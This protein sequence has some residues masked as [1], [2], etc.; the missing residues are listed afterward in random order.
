[1]VA[2][3]E[4]T[5]T[6]LF[7]DIE[8]ST[9]LLR[10]TGDGYAELLLTHRRLLREAFEA[11]G[12]YE[13]DTEGDAFF[14][15]FATA[16]QA[17][18]A[19]EQAQQA[20]AAHAWPE[21]RQVWVRMG[22]HTGEP[23]LL[24]GNYI[25]LDVHHAARVM[26]AGHG[27]QV[28]VSQS[29]RDLL[30]EQTS[31]RDLGE[32]RL[33]DLTQP[34][35]LYQLQINGLP[36]VFPALKTLENRPTNLPVQPTPL[37]GRENELA[38]I[39][40]L[41]SRDGVRLVTLTG[42][43]GTGKTRLALQTGANLVDEFADG[44]YSVSLAAVRDPGLVVSTIA[45]TLGLREQPGESVMA[46]LQAYLGEKRILL[47]LDNLEQI[48][49]S[50]VQIAALLQASRKAQ[51]LATSR[52]PLRITGEHLYEVR[53]L[54]VPTEADG[55][56]TT[57]SSEA[58]QLFAVRAGAADA[59]F[60]LSTENASAVG[61][62][63]RAVDGLPLAIELAAARVRGLTPQAMLDRLERRLT[64]LIGGSRDQDERQQT[65]RATIKWSYDLLTS[66]E[67]TLFGRL[68]VFVGGCRL[69][70][71]EDVCDLDPEDLGLDVLDGVVSLVSK[72]LLR[73]RIDPDGQ[74]RYWMLETI[75]EYALELLQETEQL[76]QLQER[77][78]GYYQDW[79]LSL[80]PP[81]PSFSEPERD[82]LIAADDANLRAAIDWFA[83]HDIN[84][85]FLRMSCCVW[86]TWYVQ[87]RLSETRDLL[88]EAIACSDQR[89][90]PYW[91]AIADAGISN[92][93]LRQ[94]DVAA[95]YAAGERGVALARKL[96]N[97]GLLNFALRDLASGQMWRG[98]MDHA[99]R[100]LNEAVEIAK[101]SGDASGELAALNSLAHVALSV[102]EYQRSIDILED[103]NRRAKD[104]GSRDDFGAAMRS[105][106]IG[107][108]LLRLGRTE[109][110]ERPLAVA[111]ELGV[112]LQFPEGCSYPMSSLATAAANAA[113][114]DRAA[115]LIGAT[116]ALTEQHGIAYDEVEQSA[117][118]ATRAS[119]QHALGETRFITLTDKGR[120]TS[121]EAIVS[122][123]LRRD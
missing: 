18:S 98:E 83:A 12:G 1:V 46:S 92:T 113:E 37:I 102:G 56:E 69:E 93:A 9:R 55:F 53:P 42:P 105:Y 108:A 5:V 62:I 15:A 33:K 27:G 39:A 122:I 13:V 49:E 34:Q 38:K 17:V 16:N 70:A 10:E 47:L 65:L 111:L 50:G 66:G 6:L 76:E 91:V 67:Q 21:G 45:Q 22:V 57:G 123:A 58:V 19:A 106:N 41:L 86:T 11:H 40:N 84:D 88:E 73:R 68:G 121:L 23:R 26:A 119:I 96:A 51:V 89:G 116:D 110:A 117:R 78:A 95:G 60:E 36:D 4:G 43:G 28:L 74:P 90:D 30:N 71:A 54:L 72:S 2:A 75:R 107:H 8:G 80:T 29:T 48:V 25:G 81:V 3:P 79:L 97:P 20:L 115:L 61:G 31:L 101:K 109:D 104:A 100:S 99:V 94:G 82:V 85:A 24:E 59:G 7:T 103:A 52:E 35:R 114:W 64:L 87:G 14:V 44:V 118:D 77:H 63:V 112:K 120:K 32:H